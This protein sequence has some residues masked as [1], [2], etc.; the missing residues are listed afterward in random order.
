M[1]DLGPPSGDAEGAGGAEGT[2]LLVSDEVNIAAIVESAVD[3]AEW[4]CLA[5]GEKPKYPPVRSGEYLMQK[6]HSTVKLS[7]A[8]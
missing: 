1:P 6:F 3:I 5:A 4:T 2:V 8:K 7:T